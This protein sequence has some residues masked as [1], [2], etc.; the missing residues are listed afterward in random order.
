[1]SEQI[2]PG[3]GGFPLRKQRGELAGERLRIW[4]K[5][6]LLERLSDVSFFLPIDFARALP[7]R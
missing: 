5:L 3:T 4:V 2:I 6:N 1:M 7:S